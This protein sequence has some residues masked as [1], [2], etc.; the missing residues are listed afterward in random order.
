[1]HNSESVFETLLIIT[2]KR[3]IG[4]LA[5]GNSSIERR[6]LCILKDLYSLVI[7]LILISMPATNEV[8][9]LV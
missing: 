2:K 3:Y 7:E 8:L 1:M 5:V 6:H 9:E 4:N